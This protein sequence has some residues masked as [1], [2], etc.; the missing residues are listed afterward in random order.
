MKIKPYV[1]LLGAVFLIAFMLRFYKLGEVPHGFYQDESAIGYNAYSI[2]KTGKDEY[3]KVFPVYFKSFGDYKLPLYVYATIPSISVFGMTEFAVR[4]PSAFF[5][6]LTVVVFYFLVLRLFNNRNFALLSTFL[7]A[8]NPWHI[9][10]GRATFEVSICLFLFILGTLLIH[11]YFNKKRAGA[12]ILGTLSF[13]LVMYGYN[14]TRI[15]S[16]ILYFIVLFSFRKKN[17]KIG[18]EIWISAV[19]SLIALTPFVV[20][21]FSDGGA[22][23]ASGTLVFSSAAVQAPLLELRSYFVFLPNIISSLLFGKPTLTVWQTIQNI[24]SYFSV[25]FF[26]VSGSA[27]GNH[28]IGNVGQFYIFEL[29][30]IIMGVV[31]F[32]KDRYRRLL[33]L[34]AAA[35]IIVASLTR[36]IPHAT[37]SYFL[38]FPMILFSAKGLLYSFNKVN[39]LKTNY[40]LI[41]SVLIL[42]II[43]Y[44]V[45]FYLFSYYFRFP[46]FYAKSWR[47]ADK[48]VALF[49]EQN[50]QKYSHII[51]DNNAGYIY[52]SLL[53]YNK[54][55]PDNFIN[56]VTRSAD[57]SEGF[58][59]VLSFGKYEFKDVDWTKDYKSGTLIIT[60]ASQKPKEIPMLKTVYYP[61]RPV[62]IAKGQEILAYPIEEIAYVMV[63]GK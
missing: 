45:I 1:V 8:I 30:L 41:L 54:Y 14:L 61:K 62:V 46:I 23:S 7:L 28:G 29:P 33:F 53:F 56:T 51:F 43:S 50:Q 10:Y 48:D 9:H 27:H 38:I 32:F 42:G 63:E 44:S 21:L 36:D 58:S 57:D 25:S 18:G 52:T 6:F 47:S 20:G 60:T 34:W 22:S 55:D 59:H 5:G 19:T 13:L 4:F 11:E 40:R 26:F 39:L 24:A 12:F 49:L 35:V 31:M 15:L 3:G 2:L 16:P 37:R 17:S